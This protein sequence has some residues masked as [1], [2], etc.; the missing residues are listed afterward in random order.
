MVVYA[1]LFYM[2]GATVRVTRKR[3]EDIDVSER[4]SLMV[5]IHG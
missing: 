3:I 4:C 5:L 2:E 1:R